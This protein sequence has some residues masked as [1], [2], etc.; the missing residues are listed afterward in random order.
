M[1][2]EST[3]KERGSRYGEFKEHARISQSIK[4]AMPR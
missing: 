4:R 2:I 1:D 3:L